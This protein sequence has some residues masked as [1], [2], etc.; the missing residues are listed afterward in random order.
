MSDVYAPDARG[1]SLRPTDRVG[2][3]R[4]CAS[5]HQTHGWGF[6]QCARI[7]KFKDNGG[8]WWCAQHEPE[9]AAKRKAETAARQDAAYKKSQREW[10]YGSRGIM[11]RNA[12][13]EI[14]NGHNDPRSLAVEVLGS[15]LTED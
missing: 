15:M 2:R 10:R 1:I 11:L 6:A 14:A 9:N 3:P 8:L 7:G 5:V 4:C 13:R 12:L